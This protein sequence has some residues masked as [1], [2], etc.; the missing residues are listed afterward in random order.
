MCPRGPLI[1][2]LK[3]LE[4]SDYKPKGRKPY[5][6]QLLRFALLVCY[7]SGQAYKL[8]L[9]NFPLPSFSLLQKLK[10]GSVDALK[11]CKCLYE[12]EEISQDVVVLVD[13]MYL[14]KKRPVLQR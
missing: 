8:L 6:S 10:R 12:A 7:T 2:S 14:K 13:E 5:S 4:T 1:I 9:E 3:D 11:A